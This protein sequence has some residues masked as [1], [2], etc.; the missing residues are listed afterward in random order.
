MVLPSNIKSSIWVFF[1]I[2]GF[3]LFTI[4]FTFIQEEWQFDINSI[5]I[6]SILVIIVMEIVFMVQLILLLLKYRKN[7]EG[8]QRTPLSVPITFVLGIGAV[9]TYMLVYFSIKIS[10]ETFLGLAC[11]IMVVIY[12]ISYLCYLKLHDPVSEYQI[13]ALVYFFAILISIIAG[14]LLIAYPFVVYTVSTDLGSFFL[15]LA[16]GCWIFIGYDYWEIQQKFTK[17]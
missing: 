11:D 14:Y 5:H 8:F 10:M 13:S 9:G 17:V 4:F 15:A 16:L 12:V 3:G 6:Q 1:L 7:K 2:S